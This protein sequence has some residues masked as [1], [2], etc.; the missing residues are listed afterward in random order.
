M[1]QRNML[2]VCLTQLDLVLVAAP[3]ISTVSHVLL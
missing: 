2:P 1:K 3:E